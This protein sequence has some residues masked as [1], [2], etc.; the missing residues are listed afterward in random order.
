[1]I[2][3]RLEPE[4]IPGWCRDA[5]DEEITDLAAQSVEGQCKRKHT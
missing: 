5:R 3:R 1:M 4:A 2:T